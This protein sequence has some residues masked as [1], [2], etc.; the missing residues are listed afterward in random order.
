[1]HWSKTFPCPVFKE[2]AIIQAWLLSKSTVDDPNW[3][4][5][6]KSLGSFTGDK[7][8]VMVAYVIT[9]PHSCDYYSENECELCEGVDCRCSGSSHPSLV[10]GTL[11][12]LVVGPYLLAIIAVRRCTLSH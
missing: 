4:I 5:G 12:L 1:M 7:K 9:S 8:D 10:M 2:R 11:M 3:P 6:P